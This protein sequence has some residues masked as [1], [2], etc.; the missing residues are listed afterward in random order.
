[1]LICNAYR[2]DIQ[3]SP[4]HI[5]GLGQGENLKMTKKVASGA[6]IALKEALTHL[7]WYKSDLR[8][9]LTSCLRDA[10]ILSTLD[11]SDYKRNIIAN[12]IDRMDQNQNLFQPDLLRLMSEVACVIDFSHLERLEDGEIKANRAKSAVSGLREWVKSHEDSLLDQQRIEES[13]KKA[14]ETL[15]AKT[16]IQRKLEELRDEYYKLLASDQPQKRG[17]RLERIIRELFEI[18]DLD[19]KASFRITG[20]QIDGAF[21]LEGTDFLFE[22]KWQQELV[23]AAELDSLAGK[24]RRKL[25][26]TLGLFLSINGFSEDGINAHASG[27]RLILLMDGSDLMAVLEGRI[28]IFQ[29]LLRKRRHAARTGNI[30]LRIHEILTACQT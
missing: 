5:N 1:L 25:E 30:Y 13:R 3:K 21:T 22:A 28:D 23:R 18:F 16:A 10:R 6:I 24:L 9:F 29:L 12:L 20:E 2:R 8:S 17:F 27:R 7:Y 19:P 26:N 4:L 14:H 11:W 15:M